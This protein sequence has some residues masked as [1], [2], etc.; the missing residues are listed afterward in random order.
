M[1][2]GDRNGCSVTAFSE[3]IDS[4]TGDYFRDSAEH[5]IGILVVFA[6]EDFTKDIE[7]FDGC[8]EGDRDI[9]D[10]SPRIDEVLEG[11]LI[12]VEAFDAHILAS[13][14]KD[15]VVRDYAFDGIARGCMRSI[16]DISLWE[17]LFFR[18]GATA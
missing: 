1:V 6:V 8:I 16:S 4:L 2:F 10:I 13:A 14:F 7:L 17:G 5:H 3:S 9:V 12:E 18:G 11:I 15:V